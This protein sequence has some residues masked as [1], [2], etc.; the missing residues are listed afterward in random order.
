MQETGSDQ[1]SVHVI[2]VIKKKVEGIKKK[3]PGSQLMGST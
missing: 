2:C 1:V 3:I